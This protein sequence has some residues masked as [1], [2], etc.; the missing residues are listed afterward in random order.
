[1]AFNWSWATSVNGLET[2]PAGGGLI[3]VIGAVGWISSTAEEKR[4][5][6]VSS[7]A[8]RPASSVTDGPLKDPVAVS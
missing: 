4:T 5:A 7:P 8:F 2:S 6:G 1:M 3:D